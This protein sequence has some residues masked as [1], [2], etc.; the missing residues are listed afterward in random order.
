[1]VVKK[2]SSPRVH[3]CCE[4][5]HPSNRQYF[6]VKDR[7]SLVNRVVHVIN[8][9]DQT[10]E[11]KDHQ[12]LN[13]KARQPGCCQHHQYKVQVGDAAQPRVGGEAGFNDFADV[14]QQGVG[15]GLHVGV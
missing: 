1:M 10:L 5:I 11:Y 13:A 4:K 2:I 8:D 7:H 15:H 6:R 9:D 14:A 12:Q 3:R